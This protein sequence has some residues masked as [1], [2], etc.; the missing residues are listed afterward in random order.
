MRLRLPGD[1]KRKHVWQPELCFAV[2]NCHGVSLS[3]QPILLR[4]SMLLRLLASAPV[5]H[6]TKRELENMLLT[7]IL[8]LRHV[9]Q[10]VFVRRL[11]S[12]E[13]NQTITV[14]T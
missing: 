7:F 10:P 12:C 2:L 4:P 8:R 6:P 11:I 13:A 5:R 1:R 14:S 3:R 9:R